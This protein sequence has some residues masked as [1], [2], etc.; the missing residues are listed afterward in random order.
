MRRK[1]P[2]LLFAVV[3]MA[4]GIVLYQIN[5]ADR[6]QLW[7]WGESLADKPMT[8]LILILTQTFLY[9]FA[10]PGGIMFWVV[11][12]IYAPLPATLILTAGNM[13]GSFTAYA[14]ASRL[15]RWV[16]V[17]LAGHRAFQILSRRSDFTTQCALRLLPGFPHLILNFGGGVLHLPLRPYALA[18][19]IGSSLKW[20][21]YCWALHGLV[22]SDEL[23]EVLQPSTLIPLVLL[24]VFLIAGNWAARH[25]KARRTT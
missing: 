5:P 11:A 6:Q 25:I 2:H 14:M 15:S 17:R 23:E 21:V 19:L 8:P 4:L 9:T 1:L 13:L 7:N 16:R 3:V 20:G 10:L 12:P 22:E 24:T 18:T